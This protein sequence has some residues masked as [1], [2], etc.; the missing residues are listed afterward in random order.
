[1]KKSLAA[2]L[3]LLGLMVALPTNSLSAAENPQP[4]AQDDDE[5]NDNENAEFVEVVVARVPI[6]LGTRLE[7]EFLTTELRPVSN[8]AVRGG[9]FYG[10]AEEVVGSIVQTQ[11]AQGQ[12]ILAPMV[13]ID[14][15]DLADIGS[16]LALHVD[17]GRVA[18]AV[19]IDALS[20]ASYAMRPGDFVDVLMSFDLIQLDLE[21][22]TPLPNIAR[23]VDEDSLENGESFLFPAVSQG[24]LEL[25][26]EINRVVEV[27]PQGVTLDSEESSIAQQ[28]PRR[29]SQLTIQ[30]AEVLW[31]GNW[32]NTDQG[33]WDGPNNYALRVQLEEL[34]RLEQ[35]LD[36]LS[37]EAQELLLLNYGLQA[38]TLRDQLE[39]ARSRLQQI[40]P[41]VALISLPLQDALTMKWALEEPG[42]DMDLVLRSQ[43]DQAVFVTT[44]VSLPQLVEQA[45]LAI[46]EPIEFGLEP[47]IEEFDGP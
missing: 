9:F 11:I 4:I 33:G 45:G 29:T 21:F 17:N 14:A 5:G 36:Q 15:I 20:A 41:D 27:V 30:Q 31:L 24:R 35:E 19:P 6:P 3:L 7:E 46:P 37:S 47:N 18:V 28:I 40:S 32:S 1:M 23:L 22:Q 16:D 25:I 10:A 8:M 42:I 12:E 44:A 26:P 13:A 43:G 2:V 38:Q 39:I 34:T